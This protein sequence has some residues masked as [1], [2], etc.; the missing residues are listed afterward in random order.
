MT[1]VCYDVVPYDGGWAVVIAPGGRESFGNKK[2][3]FDA[4]MVWARKLRFLGYQMNVR[5]PHE[6]SDGERHRQ[7]LQ[8]H[9]A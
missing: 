1:Q 9:V 2:D 7:D 3:A 5:K 4:A 6:H 8:A